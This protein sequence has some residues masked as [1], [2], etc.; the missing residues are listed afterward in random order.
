VG[1]NVYG[2]G[3]SEGKWLG[4]G[5]GGLGDAWNVPVDHQDKVVLCALYH[6]KHRT[7]HIEKSCQRSLDRK[8]VSGR[9]KYPKDK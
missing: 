5:S 7:W 3:D 2:S 6:G 8:G 4:G 1:L 9:Q